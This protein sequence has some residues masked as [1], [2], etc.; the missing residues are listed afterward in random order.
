MSS[1]EKNCQAILANQDVEKDQDAKEIQDLSSLKAEGSE[2]RNTHS[3]TD[4]ASGCGTKII[5]KCQD[6]L[7][8]Q[9]VE[10]DQGAKENQDLSSLN[11]EEEIGRDL[12]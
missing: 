2:G 8:N 7:T 10:K 11:A 12:H 5:F 9:S 6:T 3:K 4:G 1:S